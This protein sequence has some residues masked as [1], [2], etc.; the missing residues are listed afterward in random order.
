MSGS[1]VGASGVLALL[2]GF[3]L[4]LAGF[5][6]YVVWSYRRY[7]TVQPAHA[8]LLV[9]AAVYAVGMWTYTVLPPPPDPNRWCAVHTVAPQLRPGQ[10]LRDI[11]NHGS[12]SQG[13]LALQQV[14]LN[15]VLFVPL[16]VFVRLL[17][18][19]SATR[20]AVVGLAV[21]LLVEVTQLTG[22]WRIYPCAYRLFDVD[23][24]LV[25]TLGAVVGGVMAPLFARAS[26]RP[27]GPAGQA[28]AVT[29][30]RRLLGMLT[31]VV[32]VLV[33]GFVLWAAVFAVRSVVAQGGPA[34]PPPWQHALFAEVLPA[35]V[36]LLLVPAMGRGATVG[37]HA[38]RVRPVRP[39]GLPP[40]KVQICVRFLSGSGIFFL[41]RGGDDVLPGGE[42]GSLARLL[43]ITSLVL[44]WRS[45]GHRGLSGAVTGLGVVDARADFGSAEAQLLQDPPWDLRR[46]STAVLGLAAVTYAVFALVGA[47]TEA[48]PTV[49]PLVVLVMVAG[50][51]LLTVVVAAYL[52]ANGMVMVRRERHSL[53]NL[54]SLLTGTAL[55]TLLAGCCYALAFGPSWLVTV[56]LAAVA[57]SGYLGF[58]LVAFVAYGLL[59]GRLMPPPGV[60]VVV[61]LG[62]GLRGSRVP[63]LLASRLDRAVDV[64][65]QQQEQGHR[66]YIICSGGRGP[67]EDVTE[68]SAMAGYLRER[69][70]PDSLVVE[71]TESRS[72]EENLQFSWALAQ[73]R[74]ATRLVAV[75]N[76]FHAFRAALI[77]RELGIPAQVVGSP[78]A[79]YYFP[80]AVLREFIGVL[81]R[82]PLAYTAC[83]LVIALTT[84]AVAY[85]G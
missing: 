84:A 11:R 14:A 27:P 29:A 45:R 51:A 53:G 74:G 7:G 63:P 42:L 10:F 66:P 17:A 69:G 67:N 18:G 3:V 5:V 64:L 55:L 20:V 1:E 75:T 52:V 36:L 41:L 48:S 60:D 25:N 30:G 83:G 43:G 31:D 16:G 46:M 65:R 80:A 22:D 54:L 33:L 39:D 85:V 23:D 12:Y 15:V 71:E 8:V 38:T 61:A 68:A 59:Y 81:A 32:S 35:L 44:A 73:S 58:L 9:A 77:A 47:L 56:S 70:V 21:S 76:D 34:T 62:S 26:R 72:T 50:F 28:R 37:Q 4:V 2:L 78:T 40:T 24:L 79:H 13:D 49:G 6:P 82:R 19:W 57:L